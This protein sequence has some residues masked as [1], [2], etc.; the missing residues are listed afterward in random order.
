MLLCVK[1]HPNQ[2]FDKVEQA[3]S[4]RGTHWTLRIKAPARDGKANA[5]LLRFLAEV[6]ELP[7][8]GI[9]L[10]SGASSRIKCLEIMASETYV[11]ER[12]RAALAT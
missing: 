4:G 7:G 2:R 6:L 11:N 1:V 12:L 10:K 8:S 3:E 9:R 5:Y